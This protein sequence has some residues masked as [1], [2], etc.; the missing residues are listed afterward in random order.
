MREK[1]HGDIFFEGDASLVWAGLAEDEGE[2]SGFA[3]AI[4]A[5]ETDAVF[6]V[7]LEGDVAEESA[8]RE[9]FTELREREHGERAGRG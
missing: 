7:N 4:G 8:T 3:R 9:R 6:A 2:E 5:D 1:A